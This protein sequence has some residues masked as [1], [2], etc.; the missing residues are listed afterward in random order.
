MLDNVWGPNANPFSNTV[1]VHIARL[2]KIINIEQK[3]Y[4]KTI[5]CV[6]YILEI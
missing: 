6:G 2:R 1:D 3:E 5:H 4:L